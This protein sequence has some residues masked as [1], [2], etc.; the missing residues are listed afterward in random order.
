MLLHD[1]D[2]PVAHGNARQKWLDAAGVADRV[3]AAHGPHFSS[4]ILPLEAASQ[5][6]GVALR[7]GRWSTTTSRP[8]LV[9]LFATEM[10][11][12]AR[13]TLS[14]PRS[15]PIARQSPPSESGY[16]KRQVVRALDSGGAAAT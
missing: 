6:L 11:P 4:N 1:D 3:D 5:K 12:S 14:A 9:A 8:R 16:W 2:E 7:R 13:I 10:K 15:L